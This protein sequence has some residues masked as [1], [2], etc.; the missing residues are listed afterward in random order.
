MKS[1]E[2]KLLVTNNLPVRPALGPRQGL[3]HDFLG[4]L[5]VASLGAHYR[6]AIA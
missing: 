5:F 2:K 1:Y 4:A 3:Q 6:P